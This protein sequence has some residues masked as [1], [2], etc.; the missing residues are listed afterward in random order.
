MQKIDY[1]RELNCAQLKAVESIDGPHLVIAGAGS[2][3]TRVLVHRVAYLV[4]KGV[5]PEQILLLTFTRRSAE[6]MLRRASLLLD[7]RCKHVSGGTF[8]SFANMV[9]RKY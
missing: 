9:L 3:K 6:E 7:E 5:R 8:H 2:G 1:R 4:E